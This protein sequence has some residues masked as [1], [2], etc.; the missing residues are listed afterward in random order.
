MKYERRVQTK[1]KSFYPFC[2]WP[3][4][5][6]EYNRS[7][8]T[9]PPRLSHLSCADQPILM[10]L[11]IEIMIFWVHLWEIEITIVW[12]KLWEIEIMI[13]LNAPL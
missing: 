8:D 10:K 4:I 2:Q 11:E 3:Q 5:V 6:V 9:A 7:D 12:V 1:Q 13:V